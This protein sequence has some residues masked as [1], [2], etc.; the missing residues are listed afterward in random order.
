MKN[1]SC[2]ISPF[3]IRGSDHAVLRLL[4][5]LLLLL[6]STLSNDHHPCATHAFSTTTTISSSIRRTI[7]NS[8]SSNNMNSRNSNPYVPSLSF[9]STRLYHMGHS[10][11][12]HHQHHAAST[13]TTTTGKSSSLTPKQKLRRRIVIFVVCWCATCGISLLRFQGTRRLQKSDWWTF[14]ITSITLCSADRIR[15]SFQSQFDKLNQFKN[16]IV[17]HAPQQQQQST[18]TTTT[19]NGG[20]DTSTTTTAASNH[21]QQDVQQQQQQQQ[22]AREADRVTWFGVGINLILSIGKLF[23]GM[24][25]HSSA[26]IADAGH[27][28]SDLISD[29]ITLLTVNIARLPA[30]EDHPY[31]HWKFEAIGSLFLS[32]TLMATAI[33][34]G[35]MANKKLLVT[36]SST[37]ATSTASTMIPGK[38]ALVMAAISIASKE[39]LYRITKNVGERIHSQVVIANAWHHRSDA[40]SSVLA[41]CSIAW[42]RSTGV[43]AA[44]A[45]AGLLVAGMIGMTGFE[46]LMESIQQLSD[47]ANPS[48]QNQCE[49]DCYNLLQKYPDD[50]EYITSIKARQV[51]SLRMVEIQLTCPMHLSTTAARAVEERWKFWLTNQQYY[52]YD[53][54]TVHAK[55]D[56]ILSTSEEAEAPFAMNNNNNNNSNGQHQQEDPQQQQQPQTSMELDNTDTD[57]DDD[58]D[59]DADNVPNNNNNN[60]NSA[61][62]A[63]STTNNNNMS[64]T[65]TT[66]SAAISSADSIEQLTRQ[67]A[68][69]SLCSKTGGQ[70]DRVTVHYH[71]GYQTSVDVIVVMPATT[72][73]APAPTQEQQEDDS[74]NLRQLMQQGQKLRNDLLELD[75]IDNANIYW[76]L[77]ASSLD[78]GDADNMDDNDD[79][80]TPQTATTTTT[81]T[82]TAETTSIANHPQ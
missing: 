24:T 18:T 2:R 76:D 32:L 9:S 58:I 20:N 56:I 22:N 48:L 12:H 46:I 19:T 43:L 60:N 68:L 47:G 38:L 21:Q 42:A 80:N 65:T 31:G 1:N 8:R 6:L 52:G 28:V 41:L 57:T 59:D 17:K 25:Q 82:S 81:T 75:E 70:V 77:T 49:E 54:A 50:V 4:L 10:H 62:L 78:D 37:S 36:L 44:D 14:G 61:S 79:D 13:T 34:I 69:L 3:M 5:L 15:K 27:S 72:T 53:E 45:A 26:L 73:T 11:D 7:N 23:F 55:P 40:Y 39:W 16:Q 51:G 66:T 74:F 64:S 29:F 33:S 71:A 35:T 30:D 67:Q 63:K